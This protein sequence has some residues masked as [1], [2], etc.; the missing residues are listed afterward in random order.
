MNA[1]L[2]QTGSVDV[3]TLSHHERRQAREEFSSLAGSYIKLGSHKSTAATAEREMRK[4]NET[5]L[6]HY[7]AP[8]I[9]YDSY[10]TKN[11]SSITN[12]GQPVFGHIANELALPKQRS[13]DG[14]FDPRGG[15]RD[16]K[17]GS[18]FQR[19]TDISNPAADE[20][21]RKQVDIGVHKEAL[22]QKRAQD[23]KLLDQ[24]SGFNVINHA[25]KGQGPPPYRGGKRRI[26]MHVSDEIA[27]NSRIQLRESLGR[28]NMPHSSGVKHE[29]RQKVL[30]NEGLIQTRHCAILQPGKADLP[31]Y[32]IEDNFGKSQYPGGPKL[33]PEQRHGLFELREP[34]KFTP[35]KQE[36][37]PSG[38]PAL[39][40]SWGSG[41][42]ISNS[43]LRGRLS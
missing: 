9:T 18:G 29:Y 12:L 32:G 34:G 16:T 35:R 21:A 5:F 31:S 43:A 33:P 4:Y 11:S 24:K 27:A 40:H 42:D 19:K 7:T 10:A 1:M 25:P 39:V 17:F 15:L 30:L 13:D 20:I 14:T 23:L 41:M 36:N 26:E 8:G 6:G 38:N 37:N 22:T 3:T 28:F 2:Q